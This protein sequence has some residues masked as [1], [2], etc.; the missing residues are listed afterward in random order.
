MENTIYSLI[1]PLLALLMVALTRRVLLSLGAGIIVG[2][3]MLNDF[4]IGATAMHIWE[5]VRGIFVVQNKAGAWEVNTWNVFILL[6]LLLLGIMT[7]LIAIAGGS[8]AF[9]EWASKKVKSRVGAQVLTIVLG[10]I[11]FIDDYFNSL[12]VGNVSRPL[13]DRHR[14]SRAKLAYYIDSTAAPV[15][16]ISPVSSWGAYIIG[17]IGTILA[18]HEVTNVGALEAFIKIIPMN[19]YAISA[20]LLVFATALFNIN[21]FSMKTHEERAVNE[22]LVHDPEKKQIPGE[23]MDL[24]ESD[25]GKVGDLIWPI[26]ALIVGTVAAMLYTGAQ[27]TQGEV[28]LLA[29][30]ENT[31]VALSLVIGALIGLAVTLG[32]FLVKGL[33]ENHLGLGTWKGIQSMLPAIYILLFAWVIVAI[34]DEIGTGKYLAGVVDDNIN[35]AFLPVLLFVISGIMAFATGTSWGTFGVMMPIA[36]EIAA[37][38]DITFLL[39]VLAAV[40]AGSVFGD[41]CS[42][43]SDTTILSSTGAGSNHIDHVMTQLPYALLAA[44]ISAIGFLVLGFTQSVLIAL[45]VSVVL[46]LIVSFILKNAD[47]VNVDTS[48]ETSPEK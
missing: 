12:A 1:P 29:M 28:T 9:G 3:L 27:A 5:I 48:P 15:C 46:M 4:N 6:F 8:R 7:S 41:H 47:A 39:P 31:D 20:L 19:I 16:V 13:T 23:Q 17:L 32:F 34:I 21:L 24:P 44:V 38:T 14:I 43:I 25:K 42:P 10:L 22:G 33:P 11:I 40:L 35:I 30:F 36:G 26:V 2:A 37:A 45:F 18:T